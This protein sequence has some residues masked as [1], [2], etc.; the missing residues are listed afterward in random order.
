MAKTAKRAARKKAPVKKAPARKA[1]AKKAPAK[2][3]PNKAGDL[4]EDR[5]KKRMKVYG[6]NFKKPVAVFR[7]EELGDFK[8]DVLA[9]KKSVGGEQGFALATNGMSDHR[10]PKP[11]PSEAYPQ[12]E[13][14]WFTRDVTPEKVEFLYWVATQ[15]FTTHKPVEFGEFVSAPKAPLSGCEAKDVTFLRPITTSER[16][17]HTDLA[18]MAGYFE[19]FVMHLLLPKEFHH[20]KKSDRNF[21]QFLDLLDKNGY[22]LFFDP[23]RKSY[24]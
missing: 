6:A 4:I 1:R 15:P 11:K 23:K 22:P 7:G 8:I 18:L 2:A 9:F 5:R 3:T 14:L 16:L 13:L 17:M 12:V 24:L 21:Y 19:L 20:V 10:T